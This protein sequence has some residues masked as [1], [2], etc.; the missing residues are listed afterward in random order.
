MCFITYA[1]K[2]TT[3]TATAINTECVKA[4]KLHECLAFLSSSCYHYTVYCD[5]WPQSTHLLFKATSQ[6]PT[7]CSTTTLG[8][9]L[10]GE[11]ATASPPWWKPPCRAGWNVFARSWWQVMRRRERMSGISKCAGIFINSW[12]L[13]GH[14]LLIFAG[15]VS[16]VIQIFA[17]RK[18]SV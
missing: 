12:V 7:T 9:M 14:I 15:Q 16:F 11:T 6:S 13:L 2:F 1:D 17:I 10:R 18:F 3:L 4:N 5:L 8:W